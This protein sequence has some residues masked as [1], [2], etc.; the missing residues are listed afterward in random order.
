MLPADVKPLA[1]RGQMLPL[2]LRPSRRLAP[3][4]FGIAPGRQQLRM[5][6]DQIGQRRID[7][8]AGLTIPPGQLDAGDQLLEQARVDRHAARP[9]ERSPDTSHRETS[10]QPRGLAASC[11]H[12]MGSRLPRAAPW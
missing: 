7:A 4:Q 5:R 9:P 1:D 11:G 12:R 6:V 3:G 8:D 10:G 2:A